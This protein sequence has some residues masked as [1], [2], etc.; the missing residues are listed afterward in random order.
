MLEA[1]GPVIRE[2]KLF[3]LNFSEETLRLMISKMK[4]IRF[5]PG[6]IIFTKNELSNSLY[7]LRRGEVE[8][9]IDRSHSSN[10]PTLLKKLQPGEIF[11]ELSFFTNNNRITSARSTDFT[12]VFM[13]DQEDFLEILRKNQPDFQRFCDIKDNINVLKNYEDLFLRCFSCKSSS[14]QLNFCPLLHYIPKKDIIIQKYKYSTPQIRVI[15]DKK[16]NKK[17]NSLGNLANI[18]KAAYKFQDEIFPRHE[19]SSSQTSEQNEESVGDLFDSSL[20]QFENTLKEINEQSKENLEYRSSENIEYN[21]YNEGYSNNNINNEKEENIDNLNIDNI[22]GKTLFKRRRSKKK[23][24]W[25]KQN[26]KKIFSNQ[27]SVSSPKENNEKKLNLYTSF[28]N[29]AEKENKSQNKSHN[30]T[31]NNT[32]LSTIC[33]RKDDIDKVKSFDNYFP[34]NNIETLIYKIERRKFIKLNKKIKKSNVMKYKYQAFLQ[35]SLDIN[36]IV[37]VFLRGSTLYDKTKMMHRKLN[38]QR[39]ETFLEKNNE[40]DGK[41]NKKY[42]FKSSMNLEKLIAQENFDPEEIKEHFRKR[43]FKSLKTTIIIKFIK[44]CFSFL[45]KIIKCPKCAKRK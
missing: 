19:T 45:R 30:S 32:L 13:I 4:E 35:N 24:I 22:I 34:H 21:N 25:I 2:I 38:L 7:I 20:I 39:N 17:Y 33:H 5:T 1:N 36:Q 27:L 37:P 6:D 42:Y 29:L 14:H 23:Q 26:S 18:E 8:L 12:N 15:K 41:F 31:K 11:G 44:N 10:E 28:E 40:N 43:Y 16:R 3:S 9:F